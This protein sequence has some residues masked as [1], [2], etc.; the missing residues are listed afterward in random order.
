MILNEKFHAYKWAQVPDSWIV[1]SGEQVVE[2][3]L[4]ENGT[5][6]SSGF[7]QGEAVLLSLIIRDWFVKVRAVFCVPA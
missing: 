1:R 5:S 4:L 7:F 2:L 6:G 3:L